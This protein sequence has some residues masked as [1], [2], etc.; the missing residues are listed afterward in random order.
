MQ[1]D[2]VLYEYLACPLAV[3]DGELLIGLN[4][5]VVDAQNLTFGA[6]VLKAGK[7]RCVVAC[8]FRRGNS[9]GIGL[10]LQSIVLCCESRRV[11]L[12]FLLGLLDRLVPIELTEPGPYSSG[13]RTVLFSEIEAIWAVVCDALSYPRIEASC[14]ANSCWIWA[15]SSPDAR[16]RSC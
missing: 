5:I 7:L 10:A 12:G 9:R 3:N 15:L 2:G 13:Q 14:A 11:L 8:A 6:S 4:A 1:H 16:A